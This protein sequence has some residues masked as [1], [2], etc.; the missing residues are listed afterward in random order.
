MHRSHFDD[1]NDARDVYVFATDEGR[2]CAASRQP[3][4]Y[5]WHRQHR[6]SAPY[7]TK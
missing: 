4:S 3:E 1:G 5:K 6:R 7:E 2:A